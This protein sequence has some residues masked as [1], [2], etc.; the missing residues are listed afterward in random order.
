[1]TVSQTGRT[2]N[3]VTVNVS[4]FPT[5]KGYRQTYVWIPPEQKFYSLSDALAAGYISDYEA[6]Y[7]DPG[8]V[9][10]GDI[11]VTVSD[12]YCGEYKAWDIKIECVMDG[13]VYEWVNIHTFLKFEYE[14]AK[15]KEKGSVIDI[16]PQDLHSINLFGAYIESWTVENGDGSYH[17]L[18]GCDA[19]DEIYADYLLTPARHIL[20][21]ASA[22]REYLGAYYGDIYDGASYIDENCCEGAGAEAKFFNLIA[23]AIN[24]FNFTVDI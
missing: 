10:N 4:S 6:N 21:A 7:P 15:T 14:N 22:N 20:T 11:T 5:D 19:G 8:D 16:T 1:M 23:D 9:A 13:V 17:I 24:D 12:D 18:D 3:S 2:K